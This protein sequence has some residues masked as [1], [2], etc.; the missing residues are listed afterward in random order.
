M[1]WLRIVLRKMMALNPY[2][3]TLLEWGR[4]WNQQVILVHWVTK[5]WSLFFLHQTLCR[6]CLTTGKMVKCL[7][8]L[9]VIYLRKYNNLCM[10]ILQKGSK[11][12]SCH[13]YWLVPV[14]LCCG[15]KRQAAKCHAE[16]YMLPYPR[17]DGG[18]DQEKGKPH[19]LR[20]SLTGQK[21]Q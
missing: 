1:C 4:C 10:G 19:V 17:W 14:Y 7:S 9:P 8:I 20:W 18:E 21:V 2:W 12:H 13:Y 5:M 6:I 11:Q 3:T 16:L 15:L